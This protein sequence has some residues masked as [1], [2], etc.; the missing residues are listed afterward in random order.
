MAISANKLREKEILSY[1]KNESKKRN[2]SFRGW[3]IFKVKEPF[4]VSVSF[5]PY[6]KQNKLISNLQFKPEDLDNLN[7]EIS[8]RDD[9]FKNGPLYYKV[10]SFSMIFPSSYLDFELID[11]TEER[12]D[13]LLN[14]IDEKTMELVN[15][16]SDNERHYEFLKSKVEIQGRLADSTYLTT[17]VYL[18]KYE[19]LLA[20]V[21][22]LKEKEINLRIVEVDLNNRQFNEKSFYDKLI[23]YVNKK[24][25]TKRI[26]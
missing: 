25:K 1:I 10:N 11:V 14:E 3:H 20:T 15:N 26:R 21:K 12:L 24:T 17:L 23:D 7:C 2:W 22:Y 5:Y 18:K 19:E 8:G 13:S 9:Y 4:L 16:L 6:G